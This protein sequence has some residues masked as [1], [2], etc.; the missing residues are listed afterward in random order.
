MADRYENLAALINENQSSQSTPDIP[1]EVL[2]G[3]LGDLHEETKYDE[4]CK[5]ADAVFER[6]QSAYAIDADGFFDRWWKRGP[7]EPD[8]Q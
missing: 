7:K 5:V 1:W 6:I 3:I 4:D 8:G 2:V